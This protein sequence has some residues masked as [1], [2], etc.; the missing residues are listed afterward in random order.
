[1]IAATDSRHYLDLTASVYRFL[2]V[3]FNRED[4]ARFHGD[5]ERISIDA[6]ADAVTFYSQLIRNSGTSTGKDSR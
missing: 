3:R 4:L 2:P 6:Y 1:M 5:D